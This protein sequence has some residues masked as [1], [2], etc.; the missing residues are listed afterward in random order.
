[1]AN[2]VSLGERQVADEW[3]ISGLFVVYAH[4][5]SIGGLKAEG[6]DFPSSRHRQNGHLPATN[7]LK[8]SGLYARKRLPS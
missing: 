5:F 1:M 7:R 2:S 3:S 8:Q 4:Y 6:G